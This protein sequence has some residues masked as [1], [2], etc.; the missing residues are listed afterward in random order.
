MFPCFWCLQDHLVPDDAPKAAREL[1]GGIL[2]A[3]PPHAVTTTTR[4]ALRGM[5]EY[6]DLLAA[7]SYTIVSAC[8]P[9]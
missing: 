3:P 1:L 8:F 7:G 2:C 9:C 6:Q 4:E 5:R